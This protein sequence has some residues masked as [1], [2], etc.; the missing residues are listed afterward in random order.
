MESVEDNKKWLVT[1]EE[2]QEYVVSWKLSEEG[3]WERRMR[4]TVKCSWEWATEFNDVKVTDQV[5]LI[6]GFPMES[7]G[8]ELDCSELSK[9]AVDKYRQLFWGILLLKVTEMGQ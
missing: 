9:T 8:Q 2:N 7:W 5:K 3:A 1:C 4:I 6:R